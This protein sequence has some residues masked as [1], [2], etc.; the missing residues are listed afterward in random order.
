MNEEVKILEKIEEVKYLSQ[1]NPFD[2]DLLCVIFLPNMNKPNTG[3]I[4]KKSMKASKIKFQ[5]II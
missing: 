1:E 5:T 4:K 2:I 3:C